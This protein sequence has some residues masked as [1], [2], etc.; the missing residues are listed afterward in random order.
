MVQSK[1]FKPVQRVA[2]SRERKA[3]RS[4]GQSQ[5]LMHDQ[6]ARLEELRRYHEEYLQRFRESSQMG[7]SAS[8]LQEYRAFLEKLEKAIE[9]QKK[10]VLAS[11]QN[12]TSQMENWQQ[13]HMRSQVLDKVVSR[14]AQEDRKIQESR[15]QHELDDRNQH[16]RGQKD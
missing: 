8:Q 14:Y 13:K 4:F 16:G 3:A 6:E 9:A 11:R 15:E 12:R 2:E 5:R 7:M 1:R 10:I